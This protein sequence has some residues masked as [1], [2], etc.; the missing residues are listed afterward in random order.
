MLQLI[1]LATSTKRHFWNIDANWHILTAVRYW[2]FLAAQKAAQMW[3][4]SSLFL[5]PFLLLFLGAP[6][7]ILSVTRSVRS[8]KTFS[9]FTNTHRVKSRDKLTSEMSLWLKLKFHWAEKLASSAAGWSVVKGKHRNVD[10]I[11]CYSKQHWKIFSRP[12]EKRGTA[13]GEKDWW[14]N[15]QII[16]ALEKKMKK[17]VGFLF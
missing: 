12:S 9:S 13:K 3:C 5:P 2:A 17:V 7:P 14:G 1:R 15:L 10:H 6:L 16:E 11:A 4:V 8:N